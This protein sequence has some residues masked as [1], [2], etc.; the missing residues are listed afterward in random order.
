MSV[1]RIVTLTANPAIDVSASVDQVVPFHKLRCSDE[2]RDPG[3]GG[4]NVARVL[5]RWKRDV[6]AIFPA[7]GTTGELLKHL[8]DREGIRWHA[9]DI[10][11]Q[12]REDI[13]VFETRSGNQFRFAFRGAP[14]TE[15]ELQ[16]CCDALALA[17]PRPGIVV[18]S[19]SLP[20]GARQPI[21]M[22]A[23]SS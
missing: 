23:W 7:G 17:M 15:E 3:G 20:P 6:T 13:T 8:V 14:L 10:A 9:I 12:T 21:F 16:A 4:I 2:K 11:A 19:G 22:R 18:A 1:P 5:Q